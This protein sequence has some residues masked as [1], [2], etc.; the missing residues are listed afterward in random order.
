MSGPS[1]GRANEESAWIGANEREQGAGDK[2][3]ERCYDP[4]WAPRIKFEAEV[5]KQEIALRGKCPH[6]LHQLDDIVLIEEGSADQ[7][8]ESAERLCRAFRILRGVDDSVGSGGS[9]TEPTQPTLATVEP[10]DANDET[11]PRTEVVVACNCESEHKGRPATKLGCG[12]Y[13]GMGVAVDRED[14][15]NPVVKLAPLSATASDKRW[16]ELSDEVP[17]TTLAAAR[18]LA[19]KWA[20]TVATLL[21]LLG[22][23]A[24]LETK[25]QLLALEWEAK[26]TAGV[27]GFLSVVAATIATFAAARAAQGGL[28]NV[29]E[30]TGKV[31][32][33]MHEEAVGKIADLLWLSRLSTVAALAFAAFAIAISLYAD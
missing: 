31:I 29:A 30:V 16:D 17:F 27:A 9:P 1:E 6:C 5:R 14:P 25:D 13:S 21:S 10:V 18:S 7:G 23:A 24:F 15:K 3:Y 4:S 20:A 12:R 32:R 2:P 11:R 28:K 33:Q 19:E 8:R 26:V 22:I